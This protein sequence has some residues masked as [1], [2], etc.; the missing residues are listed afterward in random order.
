MFRVHVEGRERVPIGEPVEIVSNHQSWL[1][2]ILVL[3]FLPPQPRIHAFGD[4][5][6]VPRR[7][8]DFVRW[9]GG[10]IP[11]DRRLHGDAALRH[12]TQRVLE[13]GGSVL[14]YPEGRY[15]L[16]EGEMRD[17]RKGFAHFAISTHRRVLPIG[18]S[19]T[20][21]LWLGRRLTLVVGD[22]IDPEGRDVDALVALAQ[23]RVAAL[24][25][26]APDGARLRLLERRLTDLF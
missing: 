8:V 10:M 22:P 11:I 24:H 13:A 7:A 17:F 2:P 21:R 20:H 19:G 26:E 16:G 1:D 15:G 25:V 9:V 18:M 14:I 6:E 12:H 5:T 3:C 4:F 23:E